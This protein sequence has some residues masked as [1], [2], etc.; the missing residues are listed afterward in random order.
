[1]RDNINKYVSHTAGVMQC[2]RKSNTVR[3]I[4]TNRVHKMKALFLCVLQK[5]KIPELISG[6][7]KI[8]DSLCITNDKEYLKTIIDPKARGIIGEMEYGELISGKPVAFARDEIAETTSTKEYL[9]ERLYHLQSFLTS[10]WITRDNSINMDNGFLF[11]ENGIR[12]TT[13]QNILSTMFLNMK[14]RDEEITISR[15]E[16]SELRSFFRKNIE[17]DNTRRITSL[18]KDIDRT[19]RALYMINAARKEH[20]L[21]LK[22]ANYCTVFETLFATSQT[23]LSHQLSERVAFFL[24]DTPEQRLSTYRTMKRAYSIRSKVVHGDFVSNK[25]IQEIEDIASFCDNSL[26]VIFQSIFENKFMRDTMNDAKA[27]DEYMI[28][29]VMGMIKR[30]SDRKM[31]NG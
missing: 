7:D 3:Y 31:D 24:S 28:N 22:I 25:D 6:Y 1:M 9:I 11:C 5:I 26:R 17:S 4:K 8:H 19:D 10:T 18:S 15:Q 13:E 14:G 27:L 21:A 12:L 16:L 20:D 30:S 29:L 23:E 2:N